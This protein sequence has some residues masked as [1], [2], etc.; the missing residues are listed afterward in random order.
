MSIGMTVKR[1][2]K[3]AAFSI[4]GAMA[5]TGCATDDN[6]GAGGD[7]VRVIMAA[8]M[9]VA[10]PN[11]A[12]AA[13]TG[14][15]CGVEFDRVQSPDGGTR[16]Q[17]A[18][19]LSGSVDVTVVG[20]NAAINAIA[21]GADV[22]VVGGLGPLINTLVIGNAA[23]ARSGITDTTNPEDALLA[24]EGMH[25]LTATPGGAGYATLEALLESVGMNMDT[26]IRQA[27]VANNAAIGAGLSQENY[28]ASFASVGAG[29]V[30]VE[31]GDAFR[32]ASTTDYPMLDEYQGLVMIASRQFADGNPETIEAIQCAFSEA[33]QMIIDDEGGQAAEVLH[34][35]I[36]SSMD[37][38]VFDSA[39]EVAGD[40]AVLT[41]P[42]MKYTRQAWDTYVSLFNDTS[43]VD[44]SSL[45]YENIVHET[46]QGE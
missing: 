19:L 34:S 32:V 38:G 30:A 21:Q 26:D 5:A 28:D 35:E 8:A 42:N 1:F 14:E 3:F 13:D 44:Y 15:E 46:A 43:D 7:S 6:G 20:G 9:N 17:V 39:W 24:L 29:E 41:D 11:L 10:G 40:A 36:M 27:S 12:V 31:A 33:N 4:V 16:E 2:T 37:R 18:A 25:V 45:E 23:A 22:R